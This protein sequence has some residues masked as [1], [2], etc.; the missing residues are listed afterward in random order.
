MYILLTLQF[1]MKK[2]H[3][4]LFLYQPYTYLYLYCYCY[5]NLGHNLIS[6]LQALVCLHH[7]FFATRLCF[8]YHCLHIQPTVVIIIYQLCI[9]LLQVPLQENSSD[10][11]LFVLQYVETLLQ[12]W[13]IVCSS[14]LMSCDLLIENNNRKPV[15]TRHVHRL[16]YTG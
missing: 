13:W 11:G 15:N 1:I 5:I 9:M 4:C 3:T 6:V 12:V 14:H 10:C 2:K 16:V 8:V 7:Y